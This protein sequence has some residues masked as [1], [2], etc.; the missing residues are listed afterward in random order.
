MAPRV[1]ISAVTREFGTTRQ[2]VANILTR[3]GYEPV[4]EDI[5]GSDAGDLRPLLSAKM[6]HCAG[7]I[8]LVGVAYGAEP[9]KA[10]PMLG[11]LS[12]TQFELHHM[13]SKS[14]KTWLIFPGPACTRDHPPAEFELPC[15][16]APGD[17]TRFQAE[18]RALQENY[19]RQLRA[20]EHLYFEPKDDIELELVI[21][22]LEPELHRL[23]RGFRR[24]Q[25]NVLGLLIGLAVG[26]IGILIALYWL[27][28][29]SN[30]SPAVAEV[31]ASDEAKATITNILDA[32]E[33]LPS[34]LPHLENELLDDMSKIL[35]RD[36]YNVR[37]L[38][39]RPCSMS[40]GI[41][42]HPSISEKAPRS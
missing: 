6:D 17:S 39:M 29:T 8:Q 10:D 16:E 13:R 4:W 2:R 28:A 24:W 19:R 26:T 31:I 30:R 35:L 38:L 22:R 9:P 27:S 41:R 34:A 18:R 36:P 32:I 23:N 37:V 15:P 33:S 1:F 21:E 7:L 20:S 14:R 25:R 3:L 40:R 12:Y 11:R 42:S 5:F